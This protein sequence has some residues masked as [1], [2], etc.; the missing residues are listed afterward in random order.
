MLVKTLSNGVEIPRVGL[1]IYKMTEKEETINAITT[2]LDTGY[3]AIDTAAFY[4]NEQE[5]G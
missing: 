5:V 4:D 3:R 2:A 1:G